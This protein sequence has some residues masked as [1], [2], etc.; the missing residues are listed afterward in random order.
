MSHPV[1]FA[2]F[3]AQRW[4]DPRQRILR[5]TDLLNVATGRAAAD[6]GRLA[7]ELGA[8]ADGLDKARATAEAGLRLHNLAMACYRAD[9]TVDEDAYRVF[10]SG[11]PQHRAELPSHGRPGDDQGRA[12]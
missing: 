11:F 7:A 9:G 8:F 2:E 1:S 12:G 10:V 6:I 3:H 5:G 4:P